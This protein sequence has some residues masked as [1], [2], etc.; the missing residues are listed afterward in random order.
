MMLCYYVLLLCRYDFYMDSSMYT[1]A[2]ETA[3]V[4]KDQRRL[5][6]AQQALEH[7]GDT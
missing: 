5:A 2:V 4:M 3:R 7:Y 1:R 6:E